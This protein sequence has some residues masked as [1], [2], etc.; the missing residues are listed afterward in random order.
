M[1]RIHT[2]CPRILS[3]CPQPPAFAAGVKSLHCD[4][5]QKTVHNLSAMTAAERDALY[6]TGGSACVRY[7]R[8]MPLA[9][10]LATGGVAAAELNDAPAG[11]SQDA[12]MEV[13]VGGAVAGE[14]QSVFLES[15][16][17]SED[18]WLDAE[19]PT[20]PN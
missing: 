14:W 20:S 4:L 11:D 3:P 10:A 6:R 16:P 2:R 17:E 15:E 9:L 7:A 19:L 5:C 13:I 12:L 8:W 18:E 1:A